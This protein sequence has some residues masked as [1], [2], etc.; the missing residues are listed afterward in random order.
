MCLT[1][2][3]CPNINLNVICENYRD[4]YQISCKFNLEKAQE[5]DRT[6]RHPCNQ[7]WDDKYEDQYTG[8][9]QCRSDLLSLFGLDENWN[10]QNVGNE[11]SFS[12]ESPNGNVPPLPL[13][14]LNDQFKDEA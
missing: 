13:V 1:I 6:I 2:G 12:D 3:I 10:V 14:T 4:F 5:E 7:V 8:K 9:T 11:A